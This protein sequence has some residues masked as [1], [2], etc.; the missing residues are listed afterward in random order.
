M[1]MP[2]RSARRALFAL[3]LLAAPLAPAAAQQPELYGPQPPPGSAFVRFVNATGSDLAIR[4]D[5]LPAETLGT[6]PMARVTAYRTVESVANRALAVEVRAGQATARASL[7]ANPG[8]FVTVLV[9]AAPGGAITA[10]TVQDGGDGNQS[11]ARL[12]FYNAAPDCPAGGLSL[13]G[14]ASIFSDV[15]PGASKTRGVN[16]A[17]ASL[18]A[19]CGTRR[20]AAFPLSGLEA[21]GRYSIWMMPGATPAAFVTR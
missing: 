16:P 18:V 9:T 19:S 8:T 7:R 1:R 4:P 5:F 10:Q 13:D 20:T 12:A 3:A 14:G 21:G 11:R 15:A 6:A 17:S 2:V